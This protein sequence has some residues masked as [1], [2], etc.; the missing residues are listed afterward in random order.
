MEKHRRA[1]G[2]DQLIGFVGRGLGCRAKH[3]GGEHIYTYIQSRFQFQKYIRTGLLGREL[4]RVVEAHGQRQ[5]AE[6]LF[7]FL[8][9]LCMWI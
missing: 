1:A 3:G 8:G 4:P 7:C 6:A 5:G 9:G 2:V